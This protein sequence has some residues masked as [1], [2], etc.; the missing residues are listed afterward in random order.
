MQRALIA[1]TVV[2]ILTFTVP[3]VVALAMQLPR[4]RPIEVVGG[5][6][7]FPA[8]QLFLCGLDADRDVFV[9]RP[10]PMSSDI[11]SDFEDL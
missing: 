7:R 4:N 10:F 5:G 8:D 3:I 2:S 11:D 1:I 6:T 9:C